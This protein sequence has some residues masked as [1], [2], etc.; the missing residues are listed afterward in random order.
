MVFPPKV[1]AEMG[2][3]LSQ[4]SLTLNRRNLNLPSP[5][6]MYSVF[7]KRQEIG[8]SF[9]FI[10]A[11]FNKRFFCA[12]KPQL[13]RCILYSVILTTFS[14]QS[15]LA[16]FTLKKH[17]TFSYRFW[18]LI[19]TQVS[20]TLRSRVVCHVE[21]LEAF[22]DILC[23]SLRDVSWGRSPVVTTPRSSVAVTL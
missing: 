18:L 19:T 2:L 22:L 23:K 1:S 11:I 3:I 9:L 7:S 13:N 21:G 6:L 20:D 8:K 5:K 17:S 16:C 12:H 14:S 10:V 4:K 15:H